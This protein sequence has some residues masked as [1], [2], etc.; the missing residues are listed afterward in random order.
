MARKRTNRRYRVV[1]ESRP[2]EAEGRPGLC[3]RRSF[4]SAG[5][6]LR[7]VALARLRRRAHCLLA[8]GVVFVSVLTRTFDFSLSPLSY[9]NRKSGGALHIFC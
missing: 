2:A 3:E 1:V 4:D 5:A 9:Q 8:V 6:A 7:T